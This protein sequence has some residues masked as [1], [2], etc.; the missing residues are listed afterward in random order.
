[1]LSEGQIELNFQK[2]IRQ[3]S[4][5][6]QIAAEIERAVSADIAQSMQMLGSGWRGQSADAFLAKEE[7]ALANM[8]NMSSTLSGLASGI[9]QSARAI[10]QAEMEAIRLAQTRDT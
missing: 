4:K 5:L 8:R 10:Y 9:R 6:E 3:A 1:M 7:K 2:A